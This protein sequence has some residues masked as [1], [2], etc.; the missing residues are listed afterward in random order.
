MTTAIPDQEFNQ[1]SYLPVG[2][3]GR[4]TAAKPCTDVD[5]LFI[6]PDEDRGRGKAGLRFV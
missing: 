3:Y 2:S 4:G 6:L 1:T 5:M